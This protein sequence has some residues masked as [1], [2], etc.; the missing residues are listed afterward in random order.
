M[1]SNEKERIISKDLDY[2]SY[3]ADGII[4]Q[5]TKGTS[6]LI[7]YEEELNPDSDGKTF[8]TETDNIKLNF[9]V[10]I[11]SRSLSTLASHIQRRKQ[12]TDFA[13]DISEIG[14]NDDATIEAWYKY[15]EKLSKFILD[16]QKIFPIDKFLE[17]QPLFEDLMLRVNRVI[18]KNNLSDQQ[19]NNQ[20]N[21]PQ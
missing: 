11:P 12:L 8:D 16:S 21:A 19:N 13:M 6:R 7:F 15:D 17:L 1:S 2:K 5:Y 14:K 10:R 3:Y 18:N 4:L 20:E 9:E